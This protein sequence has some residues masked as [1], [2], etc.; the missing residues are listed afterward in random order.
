MNRK[1]P[2]PAIT[3]TEDTQ[4]DES[5]VKEENIGDGEVKVEDDEDAADVPTLPG[6]Q[7]HFNLS[8]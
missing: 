7:E 6:K 2:L 5:V 3:Q 1:T 8:L 4:E